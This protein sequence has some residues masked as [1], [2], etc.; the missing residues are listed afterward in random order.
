LFKFIDDKIISLE[1]PQKIF[2][3]HKKKLYGRDNN[4]FDIGRISDS[5]INEEVMYKLNTENYPYQPTYDENCEKNLLTF[6]KKTKL[7][8]FEDKHNDIIQYEKAFKYVMKEN[9]NYEL[10]NKPVHHCLIPFYEEFDGLQ[11]VSG[12]YSEQKMIRYFFDYVKEIDNFFIKELA[13]GIYNLD[14]DD[15]FLFNTGEHPQLPRVN[16]LEKFKETV[17]DR[18]PKYKLTKTKKAMDYVDVESNYDLSKKT[19]HIDNFLLIM[20][21]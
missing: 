7:T 2:R 13:E 19:I 14:D 4:D 3:E 21:I 9:N 11:K 8:K 20:V 15:L 18:Y 10:G 6:L 17:D 1:I 16:Y 12:D 5:D